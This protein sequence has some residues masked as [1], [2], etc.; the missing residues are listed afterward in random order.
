MQ[1]VRCAPATECLPLTI[2]G[3]MEDAPHTRFSQTVAMKLVDDQGIDSL[4][5]SASLFDENIATICHVIKRPGGSVSRKTSDKGNQICILAAKNL[6]LTAF[7]FKAI[8]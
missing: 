2:I 7:M 1:P 5:T 3:E 8:E 6:K 4:Q